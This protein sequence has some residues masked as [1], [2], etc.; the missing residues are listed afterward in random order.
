VLA[1]NIRNRQ[2]QHH[3]DTDGEHTQPD[4][5]GKTAPRQLMRSNA[6]G[7]LNIPSQAGKGRQDTSEHEDDYNPEEPELEPE[8]G[9]DWEMIDET[10]KAKKKP[11]TGKPKTRE[12]IKAAS[13][14]QAQEHDSDDNMAAVS[15]DYIVANLNK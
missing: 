4:I 15:T 14:R 3:D 11:T 7:N 6:V 8:S 13:E 9:V 12:L 2:A 5:R 1:K 10:P